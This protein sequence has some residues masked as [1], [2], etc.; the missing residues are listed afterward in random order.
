MDLMVSNLGCIWFFLWGGL[1]VFIKGNVVG[2]G[3]R[4]VFLCLE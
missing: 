2:C 1:F 4:V 3:E